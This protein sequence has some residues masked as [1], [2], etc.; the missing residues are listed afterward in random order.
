MKDV[1]YNVNKKECVEIKEGKHLKCII[2]FLF[3]L[4]DKV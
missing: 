2:I 3:C 1:I 4:F